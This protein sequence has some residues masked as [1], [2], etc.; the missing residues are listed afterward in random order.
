VAR[1]APGKVTRLTAGGEPLD[2]AVAAFLS[3]RDLAPSS[4][5]VYVF[6]LARLTDHLGPDTPVD[7]VTPRVLAEFMDE[8]YSH[9]APATYTDKAAPPKE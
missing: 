9:L 2:A 7:Q 4:H 1:Q 8:R 6:T 3:E 5:R